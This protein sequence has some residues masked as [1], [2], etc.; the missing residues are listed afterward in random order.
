MK[1]R[2][3]KKILS[4]KK[5]NEKK[6]NI[7]KILN[8]KEDTKKLQIFGEKKSMRKRMYE[9]KKCDKN[10]ELKQ[11]NCKKMHKKNKKCLNKVAKLCQQ[12]RQGRYFICTVCHRFLYKR[13]VRLFEHE[14]YILTADW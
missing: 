5:K 14:S 8:K 9:K 3:I 6:T 2:T 1:K 7:R 13:S 4:Q 12:I 11:E 10:P